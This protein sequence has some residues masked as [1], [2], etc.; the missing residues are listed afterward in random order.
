MRD[1]WVAVEA[2]GADTLF[3]WD[4]FYPLYGDPDAAHFEAY[5]MLGRWRP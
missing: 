4:H 1:A 2:A 3:N 5:T